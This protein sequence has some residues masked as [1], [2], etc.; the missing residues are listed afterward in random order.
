MTLTT[1]AIQAESWLQ[2]ELATQQALLA[3]LERI[4]AAARSG[5][6]VEL[7]Q[8]AAQLADLLVPAAA[9]DARRTAFLQKLGASLGLAPREVTVT[10]LV[11]RL[12]T[13]GISA[14][15]L[16]T[17]RAELREAVTSVQ[18]CGRRLAALAQYHRGVLEELC[19]LLGSSAPGS[20][21]HLV[22]ARG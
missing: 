19:R 18:R 21:G 3:A 15:R 10:T 20:A 4:E 2:E 1:L 6:G 22:D 8:R 12:A 7:E 14:Q 13:D 11:A 9:R 16:E 5:S 17:L